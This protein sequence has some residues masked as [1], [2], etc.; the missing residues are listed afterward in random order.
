MSDEI[1]EILLISREHFVWQVYNK[2]L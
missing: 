2:M 1:C